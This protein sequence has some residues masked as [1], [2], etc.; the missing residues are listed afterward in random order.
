MVDEEN[1]LF[2]LSIYVRYNIAVMFLSR[3]DRLL[4]HPD[5]GVAVVVLIPL[6][7]LLHVALTKLQ[8]YY[9]GR[10]FIN[11]VPILRI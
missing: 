4:E 3:V 2:D 6:Y 9:R 1:E 5:E 11:L 8:I 7:E 10:G